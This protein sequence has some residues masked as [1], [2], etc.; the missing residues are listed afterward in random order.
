MLDVDGLA[1][2][3]AR[4]GP[5]RTRTALTAA[6]ARVTREVATDPNLVADPDLCWTVLLTADMMSLIVD[7]IS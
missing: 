4:V 6:V 5:R 2:A 1:G 3:V 7:A